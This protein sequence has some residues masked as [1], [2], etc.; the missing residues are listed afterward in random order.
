MAAHRTYFVCPRQFYGA[1]KC[2]PADL[3]LF[4]REDQLELAEHCTLSLPLHRTAHGRIRPHSNTRHAATV[5]AAAENIC[6]VQTPTCHQPSVFAFLW[7]ICICRKTSNIHAPSLQMC[8]TWKKTQQKLACAPA[9]TAGALPAPP[10]VPVPPLYSRKEQ[11]PWIHTR[12][13]H[14]LSTLSCTR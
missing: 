14:R 13:K 3:L 1:E 11:L 4:V 2:V 6:R 12:R 10:V 5:Q 7:R 8:Y 9:M